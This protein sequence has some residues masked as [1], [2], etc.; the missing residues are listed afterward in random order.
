MAAEH[1][2]ASWALA[3]DV[4]WARTPDGQAA[5]MT[6]EAGQ[7]LLLSPSG[8]AVWDVLVDGRTP[9]DDL[10][11]DPPAPLTQTQVVGRVAASFGLAPGDVAD[12]VLAFL[13]ALA[14]HGV[15]TRAPAA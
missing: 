13:A 14:D 5:V 3:G 4:A 9:E 12:D 8:E 11:A 7:P 6:C 2:P 1:S 10:S 15:L